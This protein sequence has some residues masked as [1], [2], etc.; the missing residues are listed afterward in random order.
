MPESVYQLLGRTG[1]ILAIEMAACSL[2]QSLRP[3]ITMQTLTLISLGTH[4]TAGHMPLSEG[5]CCVWGVG[6]GRRGGPSQSSDVLIS[7][8]SANQCW[9][10]GVHVVKPECWV[11]CQRHLICDS[12]GQRENQ[13]WRA[14]PRNQ[15][16]RLFY[17]TLAMTVQVG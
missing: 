13:C 8:M 5:L 4:I 16:A 15:K 17:L 7:A 6:K 12:G 1:P 3:W 2:G 10:H 14:L 9:P 11:R